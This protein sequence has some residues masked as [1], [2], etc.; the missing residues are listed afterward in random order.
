MERACLPRSVRLECQHDE[1]VPDEAQQPGGKGQEPLGGGEEGDGGEGGAEGGGG[2]QAHADAEGSPHES[3]HEGVN[4]LRNEYKHKTCACRITLLKSNYFD[5][6]RE[7]DLP[8]MKE[9][10]YQCERPRNSVVMHSSLRLC[11]KHGTMG[12]FHTQ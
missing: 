1:Q 6:S 12:E 8:S 7:C 10:C 3:D 9:D 11:L 4:M 5:P 2:E